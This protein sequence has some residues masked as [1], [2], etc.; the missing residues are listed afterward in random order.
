MCCASI[1]APNPSS[2]SLWLSL[3]PLSL[4]L[5]IPG[6][7]SRMPPNVLCAKVGRIVYMRLCLYTLDYLRGGQRRVCGSLWSRS[8]AKNG[9]DPIPKMPDFLRPVIQSFMPY[10]YAARIMRSTLVTRRRFVQFFSVPMMNG[11]V[12]KKS[13]CPRA[14]SL[15]GSQS[16][17]EL[18]MWV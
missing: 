10:I 8:L 6:E 9:V 7:S 2:L 17:R 18:P 3:H 15:I 16:S 13:V 4:S 14:R 1:P 5:S 11:Q 12:K